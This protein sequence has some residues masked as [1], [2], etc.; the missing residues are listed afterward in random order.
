V[1]ALVTMLALAVIGLGAAL[2]VH[3]RAIAAADS[4]A[5][6]AADTALGIHPGVPC[7]QAAAVVETY[8]ATLVSCDLDG[9][10]ATVTVSV[11][12]VGIVVTARARA[13]PP[14]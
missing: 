3:Q 11:T 6:A 5:L 4:A 9:V 13:G 7:A 12:V 8:D 1:L 10:V 2:A 14:R